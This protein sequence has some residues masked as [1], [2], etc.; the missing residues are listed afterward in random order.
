MILSIPG[1]ACMAYDLNCLSFSIAICEPRYS[2]GHPH[3]SRTWC[4]R[5]CPSLEAKRE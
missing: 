5:W 4:E 1:Q 3:F 2:M